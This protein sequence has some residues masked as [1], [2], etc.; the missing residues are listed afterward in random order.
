MRWLTVTHTQ[1]WHA[2]Y[3]TAGTGPVYQGR[4]KSFP[5]QEDEHFLTVCRYVER[6]ALRA[7]LVARAE[8]WRWCSLW[9]REQGSAEK[10]LHDWPVPSPEDWPAL[11]NRAET[12]GELAA[13]RESVKR[14][15]P[16]GAEGWQERTAKRLG[17]QATMHPRGRPRKAPEKG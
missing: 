1:R 9:H 14:G 7:Q 10:F 11:V 6:N 13:L 8:R 4:F 2:H 12:A 16:F 15:R 3:H 5:V 17:L